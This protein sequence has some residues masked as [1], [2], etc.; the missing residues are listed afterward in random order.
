MSGIS[1]PKLENKP[2]QNKVELEITAC[3][4]KKENAKWSLKEDNKIQIVA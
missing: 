3:E 2:W 4:K 1:L